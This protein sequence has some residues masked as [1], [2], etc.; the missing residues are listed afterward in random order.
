MVDF[1]LSAHDCQVP[2]LKSQNLEGEQQIWLLGITRSRIP[3]SSMLE[4]KKSKR[5]DYL[6]NCLKK[7][8]PQFLMSGFIHQKGEFWEVGVGDWQSMQDSYSEFA[9]ERVLFD[10]WW[11]EF[12]ESWTQPLL[13]QLGCRLHS[14]VFSFIVASVV[15]GKIRNHPFAHA[16]LHNVRLIRAGWLAANAKSFKRPN[17]TFLKDLRGFQENSKLDTKVE[18]GRNQAHHSELVKSVRK[19]KLSNYVTTKTEKV[20]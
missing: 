14:T 2:T 12:L 11:P 4:L 17:H 10:A 16:N 5:A 18:S 13:N 20:G 8:N 1:W 3:K 19:I 9:G 7:W 15:Y 6:I